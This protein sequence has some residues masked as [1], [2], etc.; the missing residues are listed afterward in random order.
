MARAAIGNVWAAPGVLAGLARVVHLHQDTPADQ[1]KNGCD[2]NQKG[3]HG[4][5][6]VPQLDKDP[7]HSL[8]RFSWW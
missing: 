7:H 2:G 6:H 8:R 1:E 5:L 3:P 4:D